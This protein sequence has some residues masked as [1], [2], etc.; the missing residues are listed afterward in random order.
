M[1]AFTW[2]K[3][4]LK[5]DISAHSELKIS[6]NTLQV[7]VIRHKAFTTAKTPPPKAIKNFNLVAML[8]LKF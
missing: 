1:A 4:T 7:Y 3:E 2:I 6:D 5:K 8:Q